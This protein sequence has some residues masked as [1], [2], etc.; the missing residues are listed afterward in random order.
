MDDTSIDEGIQKSSNDYFDDINGRRLTLNGVVIQ[1][2]II[3]L[4][5]SYIDGRIINDSEIF[6]RVGFDNYIMLQRKYP[7]FF[8][9]FKECE[10]KVDDIGIVPG[11]ISLITIGNAID[12]KSDIVKTIFYDTYISPNSDLI[13]VI[14]HKNIRPTEMTETTSVWIFIC[15]VMVSLLVFVI[16]IMVTSDVTKNII[17]IDINSRNKSLI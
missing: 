17:T 10:T 7:L 2:P 8:K 9:W 16:Y 6:Y 11:D 3:A 4:G 15:I 14:P 1:N 13:K 5:T 12:I